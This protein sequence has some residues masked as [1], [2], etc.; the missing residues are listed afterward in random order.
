MLHNIRHR[1]EIV[2]RLREIFADALKPYARFLKAI[3][4]ASALRVDVRKEPLFRQSAAVAPRRRQQLPRKDQRRKVLRFSLTIDLLETI[5]LEEFQITQR[6][7]A[8]RFAYVI[9]YR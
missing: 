1:V 7:P 2:C 8:G 6:I 9:G 3:F 5:A 4:D